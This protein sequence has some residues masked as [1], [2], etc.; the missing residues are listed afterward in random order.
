MQ[1]QVSWTSCFKKL[2]TSDKLAN[3]VIGQRTS[4]IEMHGPLLEAP[5]RITGACSGTREKE[6]RALE[7]R[8][9]SSISRLQKA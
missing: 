4:E 6:L 9:Q 8:S 3:C 5:S 7:A 1:H 2:T